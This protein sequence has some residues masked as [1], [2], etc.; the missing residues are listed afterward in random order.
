MDP[1]W[2]VY[3][4]LSIAFLVKILSY[5]LKIA[6]DK[7]IKSSSSCFVDLKPIDFQAFFNLSWIL[8]CLV[9]YPLDISLWTWPLYTWWN[10]RLITESL[11]SWASNETL[12]TPNIKLLKIATSSLSSS[13]KMSLTAQFGSVPRST[14]AFATNK[15]HTTQCKIND[16]CN[17]SGFLRQTCPSF[18]FFKVPLTVEALEQ[19]GWHA[20][21]WV[22]TICLGFSR[23]QPW[24]NSSNNG[25]QSPNFRLRWL[26]SH[27]RDEGENGE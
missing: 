5:L 15:L 1:M 22:L 27:A 24:S 3:E 20:K 11:K 2:N 9:S 8:L 10:S 17:G 14:W 21:Q 26:K 16:E 23:R 13:V 6:Q 12:S 19:E 4:K 7:N 18:H 25:Q